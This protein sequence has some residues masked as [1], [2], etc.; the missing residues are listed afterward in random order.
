MLSTL[1]DEELMEA[2]GY[3]VCK[4]TQEI[5][6]DMGISRQRVERILSSAML[7]LRAN[8]ERVVSNT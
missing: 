5:A 1:S 4:T 3:S 8:L 7:K 6:D 2:L